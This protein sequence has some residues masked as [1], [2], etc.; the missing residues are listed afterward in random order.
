[1]SVRMWKE[2]K[3]D[4]RIDFYNETPDDFHSSFF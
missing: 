4:E 3:L 1:M 2:E